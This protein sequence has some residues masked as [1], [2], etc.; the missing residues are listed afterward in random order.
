MCEGWGA[1]VVGVMD[2]LIRMGET[3]VYMKGNWQF[4]CDG[5][6]CGGVYF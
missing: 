2:V 4:I 6:G 5:C 1:W 3:S